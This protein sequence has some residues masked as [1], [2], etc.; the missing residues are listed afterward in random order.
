MDVRDSAAFDLA[1]RQGGAL[2]RSQAAGLGFTRG[3]IDYRVRRGLWKPVARLGYRLVEALDDT[4]LLSAAC[5]LL[6]AA[7]VFRRSAAVLHAIPS[8]G[9]E[10][11]QVSVHSRT[12]H[13]FPGVEVHRC[14]DM[15]DEHVTELR[16]LRVT[17][18]ERTVVDLAAELSIRHLS[19]VVDR[20]IAK[21][22]MSVEV[23]E[24]TASE[25]GRRGK[26]GTRSMRSIIEALDLGSEVS[27]LEQRGRALLAAHHGIPV[28]QS[29]YPVPWA[30]H[31]RFDDAIPEAQLA[32][33]WDSYRWH[34]Q[35]DSFESDRRRDRDAA[36]HG[37]R[38]LRFTWRDVTQHPDEVIQSVLDAIS[39]DTN[40][41]A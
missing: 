14:H 3:Q 12:T 6:P 1:R 35:R 30:S 8:I 36:S 10:Q 20:L 38:V 23:L 21:Q 4:D 26:P 19:W 34:G 7:V 11:P 22:A 37:W 18:I 27:P 29:E 39:F 16:G 25:V 15:A 24:R 17:T 13:V 2:S 28:I 41:I 33:E 40:R 31:R 9:T 32:I 5:A